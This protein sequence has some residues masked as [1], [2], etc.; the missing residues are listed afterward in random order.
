MSWT[1]DFTSNELSL[2]RT[3]EVGNNVLHVK[4]SDPFGFWTCSYEKGPVPEVLSGSYT[5]FQEAEKAVL[6]YLNS[7]GREVT[8]V[9]K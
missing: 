5:S 1:E 4:R 2:D 3:F 9:A 7:K 6:A 8:N